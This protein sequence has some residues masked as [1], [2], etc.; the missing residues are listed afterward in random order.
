MG[1]FFKFCKVSSSSS[2][3]SVHLPRLLRDELLLE[4]ETFALGALVDNE[5]KTR[6]LSDILFLCALLSNF[7][8][9]SYF[10]RSVLYFFLHFEFGHVGSSFPPKSP[11]FIKVALFFVWCRLIHFGVNYFS[12]QMIDLFCGLGFIINPD[13]ILGLV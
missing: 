9:G 7:I 8:Y 1:T 5:M 6:P 2:R 12:A 10:V 13:T 3:P 4:M 11:C